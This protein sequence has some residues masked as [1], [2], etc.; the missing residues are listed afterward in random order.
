MITVLIVMLA[1]V[2]LG[3]V[4]NRFPKAIKLNDRLISW[5]IFLLLFLLGI[6]VGLNETIIQNLAKIGR[7]A[8]VITLGA[9]AGSVLSLWF[10]YRFFFQIEHFEGGADEK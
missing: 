2:L 3:F 7:Q 1:G 5:A 10:V 9:I 8:I 6:S 4:L